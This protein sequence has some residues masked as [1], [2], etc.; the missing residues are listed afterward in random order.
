MLGDSG[1]T[2]VT[3]LVVGFFF[4]TRGCGRIERPAFPAPSD[5]SDGKISGKPRAIHAARPRIYAPVIARRANGARRGKLW[6][7]RPHQAQIQILHA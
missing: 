4:S 3:T 5:V 7:S 6:T 2:V 1:L